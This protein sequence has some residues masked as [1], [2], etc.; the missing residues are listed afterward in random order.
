MRQEHEY[1]TRKD[2]NLS[3]DLKVFL[4]ALAILVVGAALW[5]VWPYLVSA[6][7]HMCLEGG[8]SCVKLIVR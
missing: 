7:R 6:L 3:E 8:G 2:T 5:W 1:E 4:I